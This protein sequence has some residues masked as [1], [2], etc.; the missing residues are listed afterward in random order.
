[1][2]VSIHVLLEA[3]CRVP[4]AIPWPSCVSRS[5]LPLFRTAIRIVG[6]FFGPNTRFSQILLVKY[7]ALLA[8]TKIVPSHP[9]LLAEYQDTVLASVNDPDISI[10]MR[11]LDLVTAMV[12]TGY[13]ISKTDKLLIPRSTEAICSQLCS[14][15]SLT[16]CQIHHRRFHLPSNPS[17]KNLPTLLSL[18][19]S[20]YPTA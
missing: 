10:R 4:Q 8:M 11:A 1:M 7:I 18:L 16:C 20:H 17:P 6:F 14:S 19:V 5:S 13:T 3:C 15:S 12:G 2:S 9:Q